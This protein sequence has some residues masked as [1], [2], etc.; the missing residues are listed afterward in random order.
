MTKTAKLVRDLAE[1]RKLALF[2]DSASFLAD[3]FNRIEGVE[4]DETLKL[5]ADL[6]RVKAIS[7][8]EGGNLVLAHVREL[9][10][11]AANGAGAENELG[12]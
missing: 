12:N 8:V 5:I 9:A 10:S 7:P 1:T 4:G 3:Q 6:M 2:D 11:A